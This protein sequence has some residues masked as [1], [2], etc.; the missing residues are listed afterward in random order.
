V[1]DQ[2]PARRA[3][4]A[5]EQLLTRP[6]GWHDTVSV[7]KA[8]TLPVATLRR[9]G[10]GLGLGGLG[11]TC[12]FLVSACGSSSASSSP[13]TSDAAT[14]TATTGTS[15]SAGGSFAAY[16]SCLQSHGVTFGG[17]GGFFRGGAGGGG[18][19]DTTGTGTTTTGPTG[20]T[21]GTGFRRPAL[22]A[23]QQKAFTACASLRP[24]GSFG[25]GGRGGF[26]NNPAFQKF[27]ACLQQ[28]G[29]QTG[30]GSGVDRSSPAY[31]SALAACRS[32]LPQGAFGGGAGGGFGQGQGGGANASTFA[33][34]QAC[35]RQ[36]G[37]QAG[38]AGGQSSAKTA[39][40]LAL[41]RKLLPNGGSGSGS[42]STGGTTTTG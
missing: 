32:L 27:Q 10:L 6:L 21:G 12:A 37:V 31:Q 18:G 17:G 3:Q 13:A 9:A 4:R 23:A 26:A 30:S 34:F 41:C 35:L 14:T 24:S 29:V 19:T 1:A 36:H 22:T 8:R 39:A 7:V 2:E 5:A 33:K 15:T 28:H 40:A 16:Q 25:P 20:T 38:A 11:V 42:T